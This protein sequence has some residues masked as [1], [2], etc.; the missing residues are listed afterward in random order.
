M[1]KTCE[2]ADKVEIL[3]FLETERTY[4]AYAIGDLE[5]ALFAQSTW[6][7]AE[8]GGRRRALALHFR[9][10]EPPALFLMGERAGLRAILRDVLCP[11][12]AMVTC[13]ADYLSLAREFYR[14]DDVIPM[15]RMVLEP[16]NFRPVEG[17]CVRLT[18]ES[19]GQLAAL[20]ALGST[21]AF[22]PAQVRDG[23]FTGILADGQ[24]V[25]AAGTHL[26][27]ATYGVAAV[28]NV[29]THPDHRGQGHATVATSGVVAELL[30]RGIREIV[31]NVAQDNDA[32]IHVYERLG[33]ERYCPFIEGSATRLLTSEV[34]DVEE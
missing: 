9:G 4:A 30:R 28:G 12:R 31:L 10:L 27:S 1:W 33:F 7:A 32:A 29:F 22:S 24:L 18:P 17:D 21:D 25:A 3:S 23:G 11:E 34:H 8:R 2:L 6:A 13:Y 19:T 26:V 14:W 16:E 20:Y 5:P 15:W